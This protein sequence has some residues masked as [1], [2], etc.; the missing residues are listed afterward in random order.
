VWIF[1][2]AE[3]HFLLFNE[4]IKVEMGFITET[5]DLTLQLQLNALCSEQDN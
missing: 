2:V 1:R 4:P 5:P 3:P